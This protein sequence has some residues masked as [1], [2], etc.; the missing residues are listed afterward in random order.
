MFEKKKQVNQKYTKARLL[1]P[2]LWHGPGINLQPVQSIMVMSGNVMVKLCKSKS[3]G[4]QP[5]S[6]QFG[7]IHHCNGIGHILFGFIDLVTRRRN[8]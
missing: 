3:L 6:I 8:N 4:V 7:A 1:F 2:F 5:V